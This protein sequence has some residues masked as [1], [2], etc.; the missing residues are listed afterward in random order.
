MQQLIGR[1]GAVPRDVLE[2]A[3]QSGVDRRISDVIMQ[4]TVDDVELAVPGTPRASHRIAK[5][6]P[7]FWREGVEISTQETFS[8]RDVHVADCLW[9]MS[10]SWTAFL[11]CF[12]IP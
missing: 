11:L 2:K 4:L 7:P 9:C 1:R 10:C 5:I 8:P 3:T 12:H 6:H